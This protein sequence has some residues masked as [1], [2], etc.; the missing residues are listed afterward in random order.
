MGGLDLLLQST[1]N[2]GMIPIFHLATELLTIA[3]CCAHPSSA[4]LHVRAI[5]IMLSTLRIPFTVGD[6]K[7]RMLSA[8]FTNSA[9]AADGHGWGI[10]MSQ[11]MFHS[12]VPVIIQVLL[13]AYCL[14]QHMRLDAD[15]ALLD[16]GL[17]SHRRSMS[18]SHTKT[19]FRTNSL[20]C[21]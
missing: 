13:R 14:G 21:G 18:S 2:N 9:L 8:P 3:R 11:A 20:L 17:T 4:W 1:R 12:C 19:F 16:V 10:R 7:P 6:H 5:Y 15:S